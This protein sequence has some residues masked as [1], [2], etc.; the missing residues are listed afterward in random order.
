M[1]ANVNK[2]FVFQSL[3]TMPSNVLPLH[4]KQAFPP[5]IWIGEGDRIESRLPFKIFSTLSLKTPQQLPKPFAV[6]MAKPKAY[7]YFHF[8]TF[9]SFR[10]WPTMICCTYP[11]IWSWGASCSWSFSQWQLVR[12]AAARW[13]KR[14]TIVLT[15]LVLFDNLCSQCVLFD[16][17]DF[18]KPNPST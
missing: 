9:F 6:Q 1:L 14:N 16:S 11:H 3:L 5:I 7:I 4:L 10:C 17:F 18:I 12:F 2:L 13:G 8:P 15:A